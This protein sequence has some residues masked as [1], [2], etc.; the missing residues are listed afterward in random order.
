MDEPS[1]SVPT[2]FPPVP[3]AG[4]N[5][6]SEPAADEHVPM[7]VEVE[8][9]PQ[10]PERFLIPARVPTGAA[11]RFHLVRVFREAIIQ[12]QIRGML[13]RDNVHIGQ[14]QV[15]A[16]NI[17]HIQLD[18]ALR[19]N[20]RVNGKLYL[21]PENITRHDWNHGTGERFYSVNLVDPPIRRTAEQ[22]ET[23][24]SGVPYT[25]WEYWGRRT[26]VRE[27]HVHR[28]VYG[29]FGRCGFYRVVM[30]FWLNGR[31]WLELWRRLQT[32]GRV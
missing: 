12:G 19:N 22:L 14:L 2:A 28:Y 26:R 4:S 25:I 21:L 29:N 8:R 30:W 1:V 13:R 27:V 6:P 10:A 5:S 11:D 15:S 9:Q 20:G 31:N 7:E 24:F 32:S 17:R 23:V 3:V 18:V 16:H